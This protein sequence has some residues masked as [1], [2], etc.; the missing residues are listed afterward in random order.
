[1][2]EPIL[3]PLPDAATRLGGRHTRRG[4]LRAIGCVA[5]ATFCFAVASM[6]VKLVSPPIPTMQVV[7]FR[8]AI[9]L[10]PLLPAILRAGPGLV[11][12]RHAGWH[13]VRSAFGFVGMST[14]FYALPRMAL[15]DLTALGFAMPLFLTPLSVAF[16]GEQV[17]IRRVAAVL[18][19]FIGVLMIV[20]PFGGDELPLLPTLVVMAGTLAWAGS[21][22]AIRR[23]GALGESNLAIVFWFAASA[24]AVSA[25]L[26][27][28]V[29]VTPDPR[30]L[31]LLVGIGLSS[32]V[33]Q[34]VM[35]E[36][37]RQGETTV[38]APFEYVAILWAIGLGWVV[39]GEPPA[40]GMLAG[41][42][43]LVASG[44]YILHREVARRREREAQNP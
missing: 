44:I 15:A 13:L 41:V 19:G 37:Y 25:V 43:V 30:E 3:R 18:V 42:A 34:I 4:Q 38:V 20:R 10:L 39:L 24:S 27:L 40:V 26:M 16:L 36:A 11:Q 35:T 6:L 12:P 23:L 22:I 33:A 29:W 14:T 7:F 31:V 28:P 17:G 9:G 8:S 32:G 5:L 2:A 21:M 1:M